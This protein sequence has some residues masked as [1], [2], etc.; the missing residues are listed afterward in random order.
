MYVCVRACVHI[1]ACVYAL[2]RVCMSAYII[3]RLVMRNIPWLSINSLPMLFMYNL[4]RLHMYNICAVVCVQKIQ[5]VYVQC[6]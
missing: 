2:M 1:N 4:P 6:T 5:I 3:S